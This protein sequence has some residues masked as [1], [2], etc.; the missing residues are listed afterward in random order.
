VYVHRWH[1]A[2]VCEEPTVV[3]GDLLT[4]ELAIPYG[5]GDDHAEGIGLLGGAADGRLLVVYDS[6]APARLTD[7]GGVLADVVELP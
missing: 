3:R 4:R 6:P 5:D 7:D 2:C 1:G